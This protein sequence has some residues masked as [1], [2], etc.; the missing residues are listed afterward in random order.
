MIMQCWGGL[1]GGPTAF[2]VQPIPLFDRCLLIVGLRDLYVATL[3]R[4]PELVTI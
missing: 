4:I 1:E 2:K 3:A